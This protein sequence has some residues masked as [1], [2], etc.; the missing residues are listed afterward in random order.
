MG[1]FFDCF[2]IPHDHS[3]RRGA[4]FVPDSSPSASTEEKPQKIRLSS[5]FTAEEG[6]ECVA[7]EQEN[8]VRRVGWSEVDEELV[9][10]AKFLKACGTL[11][12]TPAE[13][14]KAVSVAEGSEKSD[15]GKAPSIQKSSSEYPAGIKQ[16]EPF[17]E[18]PERME[19]QKAYSLLESSPETPEEIQKA[20]ASAA[21]FR[22]SHLRGLTSVLQSSPYPTPRK[23]TDDMQTPGTVFATN[24]KSLSKGSARIRSQYVYTVLNP[25]E[26]LA[27]QQELKDENPVLEGESLQKEEHLSDE[28]NATP[29]PV[30]V[31]NENAVKKE[32]MGDATLSSW[33]K[34]P[35]TSDDGDCRN[36]RAASRRKPNIGKDLGDRPIIGLVAAH[37]NEQEEALH[38]SPKWWDGNGI[39]NSTTKYKEDQKVC[40]HATPFEERLEKALSEETFPQRK[41]IT[42]API[43]LD[44][45]E[46]DDTATSRNQS[47]SCP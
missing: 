21:N 23:I 22:K 41:P 25:I 14:R 43:R 33:L 5:L 24:M 6:E 28:G 15:L 27:E 47:I 36:H 26:N 12:Q 35:W 39:P 9:E 7:K 34:P 2:R 1:C 45:M 19:L 40:W 3:R 38:V 8:L 13:I 32:N 10:E 37:W 42:G 31:S 20:E 11:P 17:A 44:E 16:P 4:H 18:N 29:C 30:M 46:G